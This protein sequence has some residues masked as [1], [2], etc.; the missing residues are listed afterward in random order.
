MKKRKYAV[1]FPINLENGRCCLCKFW[2]I[3]NPTKFDVSLENMS[4]SN[5]IILKEQI[6]REYFF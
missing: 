3:T 6:F 1:E 2:I 4:Y 5:F